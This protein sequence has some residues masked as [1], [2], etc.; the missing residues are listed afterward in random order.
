MAGHRSH[1]VVSI[2][3][4]AWFSIDNHHYLLT[5]WYLAL[6]IALLGHRSD[7]VVAFTG[8]WLLGLAFAFAVFWKVASPDFASGAYFEFMLAAVVAVTVVTALRWAG[9][10]RAGA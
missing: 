6:G 4:V 8:R 3:P 10:G 5:Y 2:G 7:D 1:R 9:R